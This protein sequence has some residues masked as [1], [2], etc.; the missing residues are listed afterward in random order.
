RTLGLFVTDA[1]DYQSTYSRNVQDAARTK[2]VEIVFLQAGSDSELDAAFASAIQQQVGGVVVPTTVF[3][4]SHR[5]RVLALAARHAIPAIYSFRDFAASGGLISY[6]A[7]L[8]AVYRQDG[9]FV[10]RILKGARP[11]DLP[12]EQPTKFE[13]V[14]NLKTARALGLTVPH[15]LLQRADEG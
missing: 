9:I 1:P 14:L 11:A 6:G 3:L 13:L 5:E 10:G 4:N 15:L 2:M 8:A 12:V 7:S